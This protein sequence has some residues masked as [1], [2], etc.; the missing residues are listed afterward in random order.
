MR[1]GGIAFALLLLLT[2]CGGDE[3]APPPP[4]PP[5]PAPAPAPAPADSAQPATVTGYLKVVD[6]GGTP[7]AG[8]APIASRQPNAFDP[9]VATGALTGADGTCSFQFPGDMRL[10]LRAWDPNL[11]FFPNNYY[12]A[13]PN[14]G[15]VTNVLVVTMV[16]AASLVVTLLGTD[17]APLANT[18]VG[19]MMFHPALGPWWPADADTDAAG[20]AHFE[21]IPA[22]EYTL[23]LKAVTGGVL[24]VPT[25]P[26]RPGG[27][28]DLGVL[29]LQ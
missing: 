25:V 29:P 24:E 20:V 18:N 17:G 14:S 11:N 4:S 7:L 13:I 9:P 6:L 19:L 12:D 27:K 23:K 8:M 22:G 3:P 28:A 1:R 21:K 16:P 15:N 2:A 26:L 5:P 10:Y